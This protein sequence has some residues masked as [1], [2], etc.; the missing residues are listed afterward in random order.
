MGV[1]IVPILHS[2]VFVLHCIGLLNAA[3]M[4]MPTE[5]RA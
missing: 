5:V 2:H 4:H 3:A 1:L